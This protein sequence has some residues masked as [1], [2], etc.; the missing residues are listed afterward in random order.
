MIPK[1]VRENPW[2]QTLGLL[3][4][5]VL[6]VAFFIYIRNILLPF[7][8]AFLIAYVFDPVVDFMEDPLRLN[9][10]VAIILLLVI[11]T[12]VVSLLSWYLVEMGG[13]FVNELGRLAEDPPEI[14]SWLKNIKGWLPASVQ[15]YFDQQLLEQRP[16]QLL[17][18]GLTFLKD[19]LAGITDAIGTGSN[20]LVSFATGTFGA[21]T[22]MIN[23]S[24]VV[25]VAIYFLRDFDDMVA[26]MR[27]LI[28][29]HYRDTVDDIFGEIDELMRAYLRGYLVVSAILGVMFAIG[30]TLIGLNGGFLVGLLTGAMNIIPY[31]GPAM[32]VVL[33]LGMAF[34][35]FGVSCWVLS[36]LGIYVLVQSIEGN[37][38]TP[39]IIG[40]AVGL[41]PVAVIFALMV[42]GKLLGFV[43]LLLAIPLAAIVK[44]LLKR[45]IIRYK[46]STYFDNTQKK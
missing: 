24:I 14:K 36:V 13:K 30:Y 12:G 35:Q 5:T 43:G 29:T 21:V 19:N 6:I 28:P 41:N 20:V 10:T 32:G 38:L 31:L 26:R 46:N 27:K 42:F 7:L 44:V 3:L 37:L 34:Y 22:T 9:R 4:L 8:F 17:K 25:I 23:V 40:E 45:L 33:A 11:L 16:Q 39:F 2:V 18:Q 15:A 1:P